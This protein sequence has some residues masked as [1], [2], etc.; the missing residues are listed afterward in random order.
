MP[1]PLQ[2]MLAAGVAECSALGIDAVLAI[3]DERGNL[4]AYLRMDG[5]FFVSEDLAIDKAWTAAG[6]RVPTADLLSLF[7]GAPAAVKDGVLGRPRISLVPGGLPLVA[8]QRLLGGVGVSGG[9]ADQDVQIAMRIA[10]A[11]GA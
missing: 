1:L 2:D 10:E 4:A 5:A 7:K 8:G 6:F 9:S 3:V 11:A